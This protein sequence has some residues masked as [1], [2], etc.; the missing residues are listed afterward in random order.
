MAHSQA[1]IGAA[2]E[3]IVDSSLTSKRY[4][5]NLNTRLPGSTDIEAVGSETSLLVQ[6]K[7]SMSPSTPADLSSDEVRNI[8]SRATRIGYQ[9]WQAKVTVD[10]NLNLVGEIK[11]KKLDA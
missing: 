3:Q 8:K 9:P 5:T 7:A 4:K 1:Q 11:W 10:A 6:V 2:G